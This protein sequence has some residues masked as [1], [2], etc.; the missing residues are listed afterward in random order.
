MSETIGPID[1]SK[2]PRYAGI[3]TFA[4]LPR[5]DQVESADVAIVGIP[6]DSGVSYRPGARFGPSHVR[7]SS[8]LLRP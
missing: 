6:F 2:V 4:R 1:A 7:E 8:R 3:A 5:L